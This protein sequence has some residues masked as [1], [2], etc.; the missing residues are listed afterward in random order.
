MFDKKPISWCSKKEPVVVISSCETRYIVALLC[1]C[2][3]VWLMNLL[4]ELGRNDKTITL[5]V[6]NV[7]AINLA[8]KSI[9]HGRSKHIEI[10]FHYFRELVSKER[11]RLEYCQIE[12]QVMVDVTF[13]PHLQLFGIKLYLI[14][15]SFRS[16]SNTKKNTH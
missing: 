3:V 6:D 1:V 9:A 13:H 15:D 2:Q 8:K 11:L 4:K 16:K 14:F 7:F 12:E 10:R 5:L